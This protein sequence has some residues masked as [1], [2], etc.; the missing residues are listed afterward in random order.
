MNEVLHVIINGLIYNGAGH[1]TLHILI[2][3]ALIVLIIMPFLCNR[4][5]IRDNHV[6]IGC[7]A[8]AIIVQVTMWLA[9]GGIGISVIGVSLIWCTMAG[10]L[11]MDYSRSNLGRASQRR[12]LVLVALAATFGGIVGYAVAFTAITTIAHLVA[13]VVGIALFYLIRFIATKKRVASP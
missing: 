6:W 5:P 13:V 3:Y 11:L 7:L 10:Y 1:E 9:A 4:A 12:W 8:A 2:N